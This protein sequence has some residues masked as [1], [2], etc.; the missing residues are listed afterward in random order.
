MQ[1]ALARLVQ[2]TARARSEGDLVGRFMDH[3]AA[4]FDA[5]FLGIYYFSSRIALREVH[6]SGLSMT[7]LELFF[8]ARGEVPLVATVAE[9]QRPFAE[10]DVFSDRE[11][12]RCERTRDLTK[13]TG[14]RRV[15]IG[16]IVWGGKVAGLFHLG[17]GPEAP[18]F[19]EASYWDAATLAAHLSSVH[20]LARL[21][22]DGTGD[23][24]LTARERQVAELVAR[25][26]TT[27]D[28]ARALAVSPNTVKES[29]KRVFR[30]LGVRSRAA[31]VARLGGHY[32]NG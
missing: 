9:K 24:F 5:R 13:E 6:L 29:L 8:A 22:S 30:K 4:A 25:G 15:L 10:R 14:V 32:P 7:S 2:E 20:G 26:K 16:P 17:R 1:P 18:P 27:A 3:A 21:V 12:E 28:V 19:A 23:A 11:W 31:M